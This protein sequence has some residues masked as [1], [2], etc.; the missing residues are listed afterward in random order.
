MLLIANP[1]SGHYSE[2]KLN[3]IFALFKNAFKDVEVLITHQ[4]GDAQERAKQAALENQRLIVAVGG[5]GTVNEIVNGIAFSETLLS[6]MPFGTVSVLAR[7]IGTFCSIEK[8]VNIIINGKPHNVS[9]GRISNAD[10]KHRL[11]TLMAG[12]GFDGEVVYSLN[13]KMKTALGRFSYIING[14]NVFANYRPKSLDIN[15]DKKSFSG[16]SIIIN[17]AARYG[18]NFMSAPNANINNTDLYACVFEGKKRLDLLRYA[19]GIVTKTHTNFRDV[20][21]IKCAEIKIDGDAQ[22]QIDGDYFGKTPAYI[23]IAAN[24]VKLV[25]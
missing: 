11:F 6:V 25:Y 2:R 12:I 8:A 1:I 4:K 19:L 16:Y 23:D 3:K 20:K 21:Y 7:E 18:G 13:N 5:D 17:K 15:I 22:I 14:L 24:A 9:L 10:E